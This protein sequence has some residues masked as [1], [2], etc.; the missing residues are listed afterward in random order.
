MHHALTTSVAFV[1]ITF[2][3]MYITM[4]EWKTSGRTDL[5]P[6]QLEA[7]SMHNLIAHEGVTEGQ[8]VLLQ[9]KGTLWEGSIISVHG[10]V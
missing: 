10:K 2:L 3:L 4:V 8:E 1:A 7:I 5:N 6:P 9:Y